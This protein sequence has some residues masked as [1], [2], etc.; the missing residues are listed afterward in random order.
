MLVDIERSL[1]VLELFLNKI[2]MLK[3]ANNQKKMLQIKVFL[4]K[5]VEK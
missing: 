2:Y 1:I 4:E 3:Q 5:N